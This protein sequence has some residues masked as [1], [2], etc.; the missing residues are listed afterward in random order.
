VPEH[1]EAFEKCEEEMVRIDVISDVVCPWCFIGKR[2]LGL[3]IENSGLDVEL[4]YHPYDINPSMP[5]EG[6]ERLAHYKAKFGSL[7]KLAK[8]TEALEREAKSLKIDFNFGAIKRVPNTMDAHRLIR[9]SVNSG[10]QDALVEDLFKAYFEQ[11]L[12]ISD[13]E[14]LLDI[15]ERHGLNRVI[16]ADLL[17]SDRDKD[18]VSQQ[19]TQAGQMGV[20]GVPTYVFANKFAATGAQSEDILAKAIHQAAALD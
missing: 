16:V 20:R 7:D 6:R 10:T 1:S 15:A 17:G 19:I 5:E 9:W 18:A 8:M 14:V 2:R 4:H 11:A 13:H 3:A 12:D